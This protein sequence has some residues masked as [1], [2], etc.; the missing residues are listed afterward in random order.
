MDELEKD[1]NIL[2]NE[3]NQNWVKAIEEATNEDKELDLSKMFGKY[4]EVVLKKEKAFQDAKIRLKEQGKRKF[5]G[6]N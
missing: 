6:F 1:I 2:M 5:L 3:I 4:S